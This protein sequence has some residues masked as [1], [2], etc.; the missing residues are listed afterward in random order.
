LSIIDDIARL[1]LQ[2]PNL[3]ARGIAKKLGYSEQKSVYYWLKKAGFR[4]LKDFRHAVLR[5]RYPVVPSNISSTE[6]VRDVPNAKS[7][8]LYDDEQQVPLGD[9]SSVLDRGDNSFAVLVSRKDLCTEAKAG[10]VLLIDPEARIF[11]GDLVATNVKGKMTLTRVHYGAMSDTP[12]Y[13]S[14]GRNGGVVI[15]EIVVGKVVH[16]LKRL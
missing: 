4:G 15:P 7:L 2:D 10:D 11:Q 9:L 1:V 5:G 12:V 16:L 8:P 6:M 14:S 3:S 13:V